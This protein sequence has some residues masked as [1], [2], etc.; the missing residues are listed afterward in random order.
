MFLTAD[1]VSLLTGRVQRRAQR[2]V[3]TALGVT[4]KVRPD[5]SLV[6]A[7]AHG[8]QLFGVTPVMAVSKEIQP[9]WDAI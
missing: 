3:L 4:H 1:E 5:G 2:A 8:D 7:R 6:V 9:N